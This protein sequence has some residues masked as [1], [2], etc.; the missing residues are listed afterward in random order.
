ML[1]YLLFSVYPYSLGD[2]ICSHCFKGVQMLKTPHSHIQLRLC[3]WT[4]DLSIQMPILP[5]MVI[6]RHFILNMSKMELL[7]LPLPYR[8]TH[9]C[10]PI[11]VNCKFKLPV[12]WLKIAALS[13]TLSLSHSAYWLSANPVK[14]SKD[15]QSL[16]PSHH[17]FHH[18][19]ILSHYHF[20]PRLHSGS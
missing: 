15:I 19:P 5:D 20:L 14:L 9:H 2:F 13:L 18:H 16:T 17:L 1:R 7:F 11:L 4:L 12:L 3:N 10:L 8:P 6:D